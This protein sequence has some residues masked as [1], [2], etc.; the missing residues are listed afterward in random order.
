MDVCVLIRVYDR[1]ADLPVCLDAIARHWQRHHYHVIVASNG[2]A[3]GH[4][5]PPQIAS[6]VA[7]V[8]DCDDNAGHVA[9]SGAL[10]RAGLRHVPAGCR[11]TVLLEADAWLHTD[12]VLDRYIQLMTATGAVWASGVWVEKYG[13]LAVD[14]AVAQSAMVRAHPG[15]FD[16]SARAER[17]VAAYLAARRLPPLHLREHMPVHVP[18]V[19][20]PFH[21]EPRGRFRC[22][23][24]GALVTHH[25]E[26]LPGGLT[27]KMQWANATLG[28]REYD[29][30]DLGDL[31]RVH[32]RLVWRQRLARLAP[33]SS[34]FRRRRRLDSSRSS[35]GAEVS[36]P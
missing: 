9:G 34:W 28:R 6:R 33:R 27:E 19:L 3:D 24:E 14:V 10:L 22:F 5:L 4:P 11:Y 2:R 29:V 15:L 18:A 16:F 25:L 7:V 12:V 20:R 21:S 1:L 26:D 8:V 17:H 31:A 35:V 13:S 36:G 23:P 30:P 32:R